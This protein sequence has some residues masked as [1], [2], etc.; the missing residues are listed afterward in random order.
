MG[1]FSLVIASAFYEV[2]AFSPYV[3]SLAEAFILL[4]EAG[5]PYTYMNISGDAYVDRAKNGL[6]DR[7]LK[8]DCSHMMIID[9]DLEWDVEGFG[10]LLKAAMQGAEVVGGTYLCKGDYTEY[11]VSPVVEDGQYVGNMECGF[12]VLQVLSLPGGFTI[13]S[14][15]SFER[16]RPAVDSYDMDGDVLEVFSCEV[17]KGNDRNA[18]VGEDMYFQRKY[19]SQGGKLYLVPDINL[20][21]WGVKGYQGNFD[22]A[23]RR[24]PGGADYPNLIERLRFKHKG[25]VAWIVGKG[26]SLQYLRKEDFGDGPII[27]IN[28][29]IIPVEKL[30]LGNQVYVMQKDADDPKKDAISPPI[31]ATLLVHEREVPGRHRDYSPRYI[32]D[33]PLDFDASWN[34]CSAV[35][36]T[37]IAEYLGCRNIVY[38]AF[39]AA[40]HDDINVC[41]YKA[42]GTY[43]IDVGDPSKDVREYKKLSLGLKRFIEKRFLAAQWH[44]PTQDGGDNGIT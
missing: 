24:K 21:H 3:S 8:T 22:R 15:E 11:A 9:S 20:T 2:K 5:I 18:R 43:E 23:I 25:E 7:F 32:F 41:H 1:K 28:E 37:Y 33:N 19:L 26:P 10:K 6:V 27:A 38:I 40:T 30:G 42:D 4:R 14:R 35:T 31:S 34:T 17:E 13:Y 36:A 39:D 16:V 44:T 12:L 29:A